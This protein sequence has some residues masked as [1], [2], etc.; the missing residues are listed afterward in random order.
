MI[1]LVLRIRTEDIFRM[2][3]SFLPLH[4]SKRHEIEKSLGYIKPITRAKQ[5]RT[6]QTIYSKALRIELLLSDM[7]Q[8]KNFFPLEFDEAKYS[9]PK[10]FLTSERT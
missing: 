7:S 5:D 1:N 8:N 10:Q 4:K 9:F 6:T 2:G 3:E